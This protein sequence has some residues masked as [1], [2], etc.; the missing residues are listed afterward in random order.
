MKIP[1][2]AWQKVAIY[3]ELGTKSTGELSDDSCPQCPA[4]LIWFL[5]VWFG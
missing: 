5:L 1:N 2:L 3:V 4:S